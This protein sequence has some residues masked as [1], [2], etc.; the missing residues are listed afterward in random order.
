MRSRAGAF[1]I[2]QR[3]GGEQ[4]EA[5]GIV[6]AQLRPILVAGARQRASRLDVAEP[7]TGRRQ[8][9]HGG[10]HAGLLHVGERRLHRPFGRPTAV[11]RH[12]L[13]LRRRNVVVMDVDARLLR[14]RLS[15]RR[16][17][18]S[19]E[20]ERGKAA[21]EKIPPRRICRIARRL[22]TGALAKSAVPQRFLRC[23]MRSCEARVH[24]SSHIFG[25]CVAASELSERRGVG[26]SARALLQ[27]VS[28]RRQRV[29]TRRELWSVTKH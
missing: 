1:G 27:H 13:A 7:H 16:H 18:R 11:L 20:T 3:N 28:R 2:G 22:T 15:G 9:Q 25:R 4:S 5:A 26:K 8:R 19:A 24:P 14:R 23:R 10:R 17:R 12:R 29:S 21:G 6:L